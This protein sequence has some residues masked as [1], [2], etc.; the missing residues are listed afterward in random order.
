MVKNSIKLSHSLT[1]KKSYKYLLGDLNDGQHIAYFDWK[2]IYIYNYQAQKVNFTITTPEA[3]NGIIFLE[4]QSALVSFHYGSFLNTYGINMWDLRSG[5]NI[6]EAED[7]KNVY[8]LVYLKKVH[9]LA[10][11]CED[12]IESTYKVAIFNMKLKKT[13][14]ILPIFELN[15]LDEL[16]FK[17]DEKK[18]LLLIKITPDDISRANYD[19][20][21]MAFECCNFKKIFALPIKAED[22]YQSKKTCL[23]IMNHSLWI[24]HD[25]FIMSFTPGCKNPV[26]IEKIELNCEEILELGAIIE[27]RE[28]NILLISCRRTMKLQNIYSILIYDTQRNL[29]IGETSSLSEAL[30]L[31]L[32]ILDNEQT[33]VAASY[34]SKIS[35]LKKNM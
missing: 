8:N 35:I 23:N 25:S 13:I 12:L 27:I 19:C 26:R 5:K 4:D 20:L 24:T 17:Y 32:M 9:C 29:I 33:I 31:S 21:F 22:L 1:N 30:F 11:D 6:L 2:F 14:K 7:L 15:I 16:V 10:Y 28:N 34:D 3:I 18:N